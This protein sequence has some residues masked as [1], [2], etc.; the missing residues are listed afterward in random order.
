MHF[1]GDEI[2]FENHIKKLLNS[3]TKTSDKKIICLL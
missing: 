2:G 3:F 1:T